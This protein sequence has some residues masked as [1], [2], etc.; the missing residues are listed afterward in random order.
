MVKILDGRVVRDKIARKLK[1]DISHLK[2]APTL[3]IIQ[4]GERAESSAYIK[5]K[6]L[7][8]ER[9]G[10]KV[11]HFKFK[12]QVSQA[13]LFKKIHTLNRDKS[14]DGIIVQLP[15]PKHLNKFEIIRAIAPSKDVDGLVPGSKFIPATARGIIS[16]LDFYK[17]KFSG[18]QAVMVG[19]SMLVGS[20]AAKALLA[21]D[22]TVTTAHSKTKKLKE[23]TKTADILVVAIGKPKFIDKNYVRKGQVVVDVGINLQGKHLVG[24]VDFAKV[25][26][27][28]SAI[29][30]V[31]GG[32]GVMTVASLFEN[33]VE[34]CI[35]HR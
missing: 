16:L 34:A 28:V 17:I 1:N 2:F 32:V 5:Q 23:I 30:P 25:K 33:L 27:V 12:T 20:P 6:M 35:L 7:F 4:V 14:V 11:Q 18:K 22:A 31:P 13:L 10:A 9:I 21:R 24:D 19:R 15:I 29:S 26:G 3:A 8:A